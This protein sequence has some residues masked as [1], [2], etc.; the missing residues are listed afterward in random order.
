MQQPYFTLCHDTYKYCRD[1]TNTTNTTRQPAGRGKDKKSSEP[2][3]HHKHA[4]SVGNTVRKT[5]YTYYRWIINH[6]S[7]LIA[8][9]HQTRSNSDP[10]CCVQ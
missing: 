8:I 6:D 3:D 5:G 7:Q 9:N 1:T 10:W 4:S 2:V